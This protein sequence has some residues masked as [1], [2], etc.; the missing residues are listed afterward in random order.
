MRLEWLED[1]LAVVDTG[2][3][4]RAGDQRLLTQPAFSRR[5]KLIEKHIGVELFDR[6]KKPAQLKKSVIDQQ[7]KIQELVAG[8]H[9]LR[10]ELQR[11]DRE[12]GKQLVIASQHAIITSVAPTLIRKLASMGDIN[13]RLRSANRDECYTLLMTK[14]VDFILVHHSRSEQIPVPDGFIEQWNLG[15]ERFIPVCATIELGNITQEFANGETQVIAYPNDAFLGQVVNREIFS[16]MWDATII[17]KKAETALTLAALHLALEGVGVAWLPYSLVASDLENG[18]LTELCNMFPS[19]ELDVVAIRLTDNE[20]TTKNT[21]W[22]IVI[23]MDD[24]NG[25]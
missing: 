9:D 23:S 12:A 8:L 6:S 25:S 22:D 15:Q 13:T 16:K 20:T 5:I 14:Q 10:L 11:K 4:A 17:H 1:I 19:C 3:L 18:N 2:S 7:L 21:G 24:I